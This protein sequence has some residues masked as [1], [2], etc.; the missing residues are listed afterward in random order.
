MSFLT[1][2]I[3]RLFEYRSFGGGSSS[4]LEEA[5]MRSNDEDVSVSVEMSNDSS[6]SKRWRKRRKII[7]AVAFFGIV[8]VFLI[9]MT[10]KHSKTV[11]KIHQQ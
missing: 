5:R 1:N 7:A 10:T 2:N 4:I 3:R 6:A 9:A 11:D 8:A